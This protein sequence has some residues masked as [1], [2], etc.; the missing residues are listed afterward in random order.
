MYL[1]GD[2][3]TMFLTAAVLAVN[4]IRLYDYMTLWL[5]RFL[6]RDKYP[7]VHLATPVSAIT[8]LLFD[9]PGYIVSV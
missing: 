4:I 8:T 2:N 5:L 6:S 7:S 9:V 3:G 1:Q